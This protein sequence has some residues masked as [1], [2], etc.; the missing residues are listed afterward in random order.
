MDNT[1]GIHEEEQKSRSSLHFQQFRITISS[2]YQA[3]GV[4]DDKYVV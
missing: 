3:I 2:F 1:I 4:D